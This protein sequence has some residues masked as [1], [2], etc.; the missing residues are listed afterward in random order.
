MREV[1]NLTNSKQQLFL[2]IKMIKYT[3]IGYHKLP[4]LKTLSKQS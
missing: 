1:T 2:V 3:V 4:N